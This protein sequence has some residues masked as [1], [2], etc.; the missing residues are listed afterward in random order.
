MEFPPNLPPNRRDLYQNLVNAVT[1]L[2]GRT[3][4]SE[5][6]LNDEQTQ[7]L[8]NRAINCRNFLTGNV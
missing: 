7:E 6:V 2:N 3:P 4:T 1:T 8:R 5:T